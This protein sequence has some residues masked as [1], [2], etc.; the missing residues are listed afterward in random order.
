MGCLGGS[1]VGRL[2]L[3]RGVT[4]ESQDRVPHQAPCME[5]ASPLSEINKIL[6]SW[7]KTHKIKNNIFTRYMGEYV[8]HVCALML[9]SRVH[10]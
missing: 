6:K 9:L 4:L 5:P 1:A 2:P 7:K 3:A 8:K 10:A